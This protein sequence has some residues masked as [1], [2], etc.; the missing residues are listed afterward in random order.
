[1]GSTPR[2]VYKG[3]SQKIA[4]GSWHWALIDGSST[5]LTYSAQ[6]LEPL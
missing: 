2:V 3:A 1:M 6:T 4:A 5:S